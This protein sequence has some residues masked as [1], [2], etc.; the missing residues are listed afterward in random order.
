MNPFDTLRNMLC[1]MLVKHL[2]ERPAANQI[3]YYAFKLETDE[4]GKSIIRFYQDHP[5]YAE[6]RGAL[7]RWVQAEGGW[8]WVS[9]ADADDTDTFA[10][11]AGQALLKTFKSVVDDV[12]KR[13][14]E[15][16][17]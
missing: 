11:A 17:Q 6:Y 7:G 8:A 14:M 3:G 9:E 2:T 16:G 4:A 13:Y 10:M 1:P 5:R 15:G 12:I